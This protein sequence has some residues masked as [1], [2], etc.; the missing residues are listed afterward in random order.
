MWIIYALMHQV[1]L[2][3][4]SNKKE[5]RHLT[6]GIYRVHLYCEIKRFWLGFQCLL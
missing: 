2:I 1:D 4:F 3:L 5:G 6:I